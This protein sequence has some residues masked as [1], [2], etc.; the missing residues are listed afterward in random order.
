M[1]MTLMQNIP[2]GA[3]AVPKFLVLQPSAALFGDAWCSAYSVVLR[4]RPGSSLGAGSSPKGITRTGTNCAYSLSQTAAT[5]ARNSIQPPNSSQEAA[6][7]AART[8][9]PLREKVDRRRR[10]G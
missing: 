1:P 8:L 4:A 6:R 5:E 3:S 7:H 9:L 10:D 2:I